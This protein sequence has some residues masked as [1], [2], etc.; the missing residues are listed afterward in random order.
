VP[1]LGVPSWKQGFAGVVS[2]TS[3]SAAPTVVRAGTTV[4]PVATNLPPVNQTAADFQLYGHRTPQQ[5]LDAG[6]AVESYYD[7][8]TGQMI[9]APTTAQRVVMNRDPERYTLLAGPDGPGPGLV[10]VSDS[11]MLAAGDLRRMII[12]AGLPPYY[13]GPLELVLD[14]G[15]TVE[16]EVTADE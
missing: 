16:V 9:V 8:L 3:P 12:E 14:D 6:H 11:L 10:A 4:P 13:Q 5:V 1:R 7:E 2:P 15:S